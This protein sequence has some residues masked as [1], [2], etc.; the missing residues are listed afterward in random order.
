MPGS[1]AMGSGDGGSLPG[2]DDRTFEV[3]NNHHLSPGIMGI[4]GWHLDKHDTNKI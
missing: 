3:N 2:L 4:V 1:G